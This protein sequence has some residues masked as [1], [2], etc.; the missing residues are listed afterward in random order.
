[1]LAG[2]HGIILDFLLFVQIRFTTTAFPITKGF[3]TSSEKM[4][5]TLQEPVD[6]TTRIIRQKVITLTI[7][8]ITH[9]IQIM[10][11]LQKVRQISNKLPQ[12]KNGIITP[13]IKPILTPHLKIMMCT[14]TTTNQP[15]ITGITALHRLRHIT[16]ITIQETE[17]VELKLVHVRNNYI[18]II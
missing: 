9:P 15:I 4:L 14:D 5:Y 16:T 18:N 6:T 11:D 2:T 10:V 8:I 3:T 12:V 1:M 13:R 7:I 17:T